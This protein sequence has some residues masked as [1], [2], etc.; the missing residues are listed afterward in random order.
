MPRVT[1]RV[2]N[3]SPGNF[4]STVTIDKGE[5]SGISP[6]MPVIGPGGLVGRVLE[7]WNG[8]AKVLLLIDPESDVGVRVQP[9]SGERHRGGRRGL[10]SLAPRPRRERARLPSATAS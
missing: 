2:V 3:R 4:E 6:D 5:E 10:G 9:G 8:G 1:A 7:A